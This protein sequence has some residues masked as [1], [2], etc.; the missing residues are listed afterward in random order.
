M[1]HRNSSGNLMLL[2]PWFPVTESCCEPGCC[3]LLP[4][5]LL[6]FIS[7]F[8]YIPLCHDE[9]VMN[10]FTRPLY[11][12]FF[13]FA[14]LSI[15]VLRRDHSKEYSSLKYSQLLYTQNL[16]MYSSVSIKYQICSFLHMFIS[17]SVSY[18]NL[19]LM[20]GVVVK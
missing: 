20:L 15:L 7:C 12:D 10:D 1:K 4:S 18:C 11:L 2:S 5:P 3:F 8:V 17:N 13:F 19:Y 6:L 16:C 14:D 9:G